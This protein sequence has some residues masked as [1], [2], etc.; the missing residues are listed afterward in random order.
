MII[1]NSI[2]QIMPSIA[3]ALHIQ[4]KWRSVSVKK[5]V[6]NIM[7][8]IPHQR[9]G[10]HITKIQSIR[11][12]LSYSSYKPLLGHEMVSKT[13]VSP[14]SH[15]ESRLHGLFWLGFT[16]MQ[17]DLSIWWTLIRL[18]VLSNSFN[19]SVVSSWRLDHMLQNFWSGP[20]MLALNIT[21]YGKSKDSDTTKLKMISSKC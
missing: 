17:A 6:K 9:W 15:T 11:V 1:G 10:N 5:A 18:I 4:S 14:W 20:P 8:G 19:P 21:L 7:L 12:V 2:W 13:Q 3:F 16:N